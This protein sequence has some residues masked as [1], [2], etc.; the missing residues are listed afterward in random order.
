MSVNSAQP[1]GPHVSVASAGKAARPAVEG[2]YGPLLG[3]LTAGLAIFAIASD[4]QHEANGRLALSLF[5]A[6]LLLTGAELF[7]VQLPLGRGTVHVSVGAICGLGVALWLGPAYAAILIAL[8][9][10]VA[11]VRHSGHLGLALENASSAAISSLIA[12]LVWWSMI[13]DGANPLTSVRT[14]LVF[15]LVAVLQSVI[16]FGTVVIGT[17]VAN[18][19]SILS[20]IYRM[21]GGRNFIFT[22]PVLAAFIPLIGSQSPIALLFFAVPLVSSHLALR[23]LWRLETDTQTT[24]A[25]LTDILELR[26]PYTA[27]H[28][29]R[30]SIY[31][32]A[33]AQRMHDVTSKDLATLERAARIHDIGKAAVRDEVLLKKGALTD[34][35]RRSIESHASIGADLIARMHAYRECV[36]LI[37]HHHE[38]WDGGGYPSRLIAERIPLGARIMAVADSLDAMTTDRPYRKA[39]SFEAAVEEIRRNSGSQFDAN[40]VEAFLRALDDPA[41]MRLADEPSPSAEHE[42]ESKTGD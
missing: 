12:G 19:E 38:R 11:S 26:D 15:V 34:Q 20:L 41:F 8:T 25:A 4:F 29:E 17:S 3:I 14:S 42:P 13:P 28:S 21:S 24:L 9:S 32:V 23:A 22:V 5:V 30:V 33:I 27:F 37:R 7:K 36:E 10:F 35:E 39:L 1:I 31:A 40:V 2:W 16:N 6:V 18:K